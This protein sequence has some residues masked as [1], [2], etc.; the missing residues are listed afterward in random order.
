MGLS[1]RYFWFDR[2]SRPHPLPRARFERL[3]SGSEVVP[4]SASRPLRLAEVIVEFVDRQPRRLR[5]VGGLLAHCDARGR[6]DQRRQREGMRLALESAWAD[7]LP[8]PTGKVR[9]L[10]G[11]RAG[12]RFRGEYQFEPTRREVEAIASLMR[13]GRRVRER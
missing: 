9:S 3:W 2:E 11:R 10:V 7:V 4:A 5:R 8:R 6:V 13:P 12:Q 1:V